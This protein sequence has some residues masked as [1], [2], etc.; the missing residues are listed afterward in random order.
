MTANYED[1]VSAS[2]SYA[3]RQYYYTW[4]QDPGGNPYISTKQTLWDGGM[5]YQAS[6]YETQTLDADGNVL[7]RNLYDYTNSATP[8][9]KYTFT[10]LHTSNTK[11]DSRYIRNRLVSAVVTDGS[12]SNAVTLV[13][14]QYDGS[15]G[16]PIGCGAGFTDPTDYPDASNHDPAY[17]GNFVYRGNVTLQSTPSGSTCTLY[18]LIGNSWYTRGPHSPGCARYSGMAPF[19]TL[20]WPPGSCCFA[21][22]SPSLRV[23]VFG[24]KKQLP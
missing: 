20:I 5:S 12:N 22:D 1:R 17:D 9:R 11:Y 4:N 8:I 21:S 23:S 7:T 14:N 24:S 2:N 13:N 3:P 6:S 18:G 10:Y 16:Y 19:D 15:G